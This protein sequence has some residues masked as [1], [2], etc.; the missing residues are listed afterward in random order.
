VPVYDVPLNR[1]RS[2][3]SEG[4][5]LTGVDHSLMHRHYML[6]KVVRCGGGEGALLAQ[7]LC[8]PM[9]VLLVLPEIVGG[10]SLE[11]ADLT[12]RQLLRVLLLHVS[13][14]INAAT[15]EVAQ[16]A[17]YDRPLVLGL[18]VTQEAV[19]GQGEEVAVVAGK[20]RDVVGLHPMLV[21]TF[22]VSCNEV[23]FFAHV[24]VAMSRFHMMP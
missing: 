19:R 24:F 1:V 21:E 7:K 15:L 17:L 11:V 2:I 13:L 20:L 16:F 10:G 23:A 14:Q 18:D 5:V 22:E 8:L 9:V 12:R 6:F 3:A 4:A